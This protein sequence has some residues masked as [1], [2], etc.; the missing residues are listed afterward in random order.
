[1]FLILVATLLVL[2]T[3]FLVNTRM[4]MWL[5]F[6]ILAFIDGKINNIDTK[7]MKKNLKKYDDL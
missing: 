5:I 1:M 6:K 3:A 7:E 4:L 2:V